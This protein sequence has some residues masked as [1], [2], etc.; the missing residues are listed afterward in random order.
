MVTEIFREL[1][2]EDNNEQMDRHTAITSPLS[3]GGDNMQ[4][5]DRTAVLSVVKL[6]TL[7][8]GKAFSFNLKILHLQLQQ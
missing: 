4:E 2:N 6:C 7:I 3:W 1:Y 5:V 8:T